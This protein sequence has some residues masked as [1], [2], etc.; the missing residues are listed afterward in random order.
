MRKLLLIEKNTRKIT[1]AKIENL[2]PSKYHVRLKLN[3]FVDHRKIYNIQPGGFNNIHIKL[4]K[5]KLKKRKDILSSI[6]EL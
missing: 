3:G 2:E 6:G 5:F 4:S 1:S